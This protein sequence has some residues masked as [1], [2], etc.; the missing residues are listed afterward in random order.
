MYSN[1]NIALEIIK[2]LHISSIARDLSRCMCH[3]YLR[4]SYCNFKSATGTAS[5]TCNT[6][7]I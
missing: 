5:T 7:T 2:E 6:K 1:M 4:I 3:D